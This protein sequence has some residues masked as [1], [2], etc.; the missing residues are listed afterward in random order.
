MYIE[1]IYIHYIY[2]YIE[3]I[4]IH[5]IYIYVLYIY[6]Y[7]YNIHII[8]TPSVKSNPKRSIL[9]RRPCAGLSLAPSRIKS[10][11]L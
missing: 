1:T 3:T 5:Y 9:R 7:V 8:P 6:I 10:S 2:M 4:Y 11:A